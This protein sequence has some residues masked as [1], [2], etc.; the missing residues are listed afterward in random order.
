MNANDLQ[1]LQYHQIERGLN[2]DIPTVLFVTKPL[3]CNNR[4]RLLILSNDCNM[5]T[6]HDSC[7][8]ENSV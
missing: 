8:I 2:T 7:L 3:Y 4:H 1:P 5:R 6:F